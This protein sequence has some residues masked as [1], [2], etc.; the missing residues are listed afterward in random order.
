MKIS[1]FEVVLIITTIM[2]IN[3]WFQVVEMFRSKSTGSVSWLTFVS[4]SVIGTLW[5]VYAIQINNWPL[6]V[7]NII[8]LISS[9]A[10]LIAYLH[11][12]K[13]QKDIS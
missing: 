13:K 3:P 7:G 9:L 11:Y 1:S 6:I 5:L 2:E 8:K 10:V 12:Y 4:I